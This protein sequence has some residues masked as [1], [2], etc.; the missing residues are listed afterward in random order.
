M[1][2][3]KGVPAG[4][5]QTID[6]LLKTDPHCQQTGIFEFQQHPQHG[7]VQLQGIVPE[8]SDTPGKVQR[9]APVQGQH[10]TEVLK[11][12]GYSDGQIADFIAR[13]LVVQSDIR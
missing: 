13:K 5:A 9:P 11:E 12:I 1:C 2:I 10:T 3:L 8:F 6:N 4:A 7:K